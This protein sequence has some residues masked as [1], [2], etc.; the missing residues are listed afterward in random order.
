MSGLGARRPEPFRPRISTWVRVEGCRQGQ[1][2]ALPL[3]EAGAK[4]SVGVVDPVCSCLS[5][6]DNWTCPIVTA[7]FTPSKKHL[8]IIF[9]DRANACRRTLVG[10]GRTG[11]LERAPQGTACISLRAGDGP[12]R[13]RKRGNLG[14]WR[15]A[16]QGWHASRAHN[17]HA[18]VD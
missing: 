13:D 2:V 14:R 5:C 16:W 7:V 9:T 4:A 12:H 10:A 11:V 18:S 6:S 17:M 8:G 3:V 1:T 15:R